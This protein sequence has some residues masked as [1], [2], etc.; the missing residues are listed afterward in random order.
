MSGSAGW[1]EGMT[2]LAD[3]LD[4]LVIDSDSDCAN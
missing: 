3:V 2:D 1:F 4:R